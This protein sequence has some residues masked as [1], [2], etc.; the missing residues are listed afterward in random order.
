MKAP[1]FLI[2]GAGYWGEVQVCHQGSSSQMDLTLSCTL[3]AQGGEQWHPVCA[4][5]STNPEYKSLF[6]A[7]V[8]GDCPG[9]LAAMLSLICTPPDISNE[10]SWHV[11]RNLKVTHFI[12]TQWEYTDS[13]QPGN[14]V[15]RDD[16]HF[17]PQTK[18]F[19]MSSFA[20]SESV[21]I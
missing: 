9:T 3:C 21:R 1:S 10:F 19:K 6:P 13:M 14:L 11:L 5:R 8:K 15:K 20:I 17:Q 18:W 4:E 16:L 2:S 12:S 7:R